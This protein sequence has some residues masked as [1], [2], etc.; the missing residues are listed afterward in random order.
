M[1]CYVARSPSTCC[2]FN[3]ELLKALPEL[4]ASK[5]TNVTLVSVTHMLVMKASL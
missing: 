1:N 3:N 5:I 4:Q 2:V